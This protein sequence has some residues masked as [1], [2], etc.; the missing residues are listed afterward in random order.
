MIPSF[1]EKTYVAAAAAAAVVTTTNNNNK[2][3]R[4]WWYRS[5][6]DHL[7]HSLWQLEKGMNPKIL[8]TSYS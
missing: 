7:E 2:I 1:L 8:P 3:W 6:K 4:W 5:K